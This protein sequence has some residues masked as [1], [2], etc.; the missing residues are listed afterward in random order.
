MA[1]TQQ[2]IDAGQAVYSKR[3]LN[4]Y[5]FVV[6]SVSNRWV[7]KCGTDVLLQHFNTYVSNNHLDV[8]VGSG[9]FLDHCRFS[10]TQ[11][12]VG[13]MDINTSALG[14]SRKRIERYAPEIYEHD[15]FQPVSSTIKPFD[16]VSVNYLL[17]CIPG[18]MH[19]KCTGLANLS[20]L[21]RPEATIFGAT[22][23]AKGI[24][25]TWLAERLMSFYNKKGIFS[26]GDDS[27]DDLTECLN[28]HFS[29]VRIQVEGCVAIFSATRP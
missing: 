18:S 16:S 12:R 8:G 10:D 7:W 23:L 24:E 5:D 3:T 1:I 13:L 15:F 29:N 6:L 19:E 28:A 9:Y 26:N 27:L 11:P 21:M 22:I 14:F 17:H 25:K 20:Q 2:Q 4:M